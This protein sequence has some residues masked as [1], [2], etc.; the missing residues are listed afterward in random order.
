MIR[1]FHPSDLEDVMDLWLHGNT[2]AH[3][4]IPEEYWQQHFLQV[5]EM[6]PKAEL[7]VYE[8]DNT[9]TRDGFVGLSDHYIAGIF[10][11][12]NARSQGIG[13][14]LL[15]YVKSIK[16][17]LTLKVYVRNQRAVKFYQREG[18][19]VQSQGMDEDTGEQEYIMAWQ[20]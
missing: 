7:Y 15:N 2:A 20:N 9:G 14:R 5:K 13:K 1:K 12:E 18:F 11:K 19:L 17:N 16:G 3:D 8:D 10:V 4:F 6:L